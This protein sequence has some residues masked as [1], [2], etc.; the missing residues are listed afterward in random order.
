M[1]YKNIFNNPRERAAVTFPYVWW[2]DAFTDEDIN[3]IIA[4]CEKFNQSKA[5]IGSSE[6][7]QKEIDK[8]RRSDINFFTPDQENDWIFKRL[9]FIIEGLNNQFYGFDLNGYDSFQ[10]TTYH[11]E[12]EGMYDWH[13]DMFLGN[14]NLPADMSEPR[15]L[16][17]VLLL[18]EPEVDFKGGEFQIKQ[19]TDRSDETLPTRKGRI[20]AFP[21]FMLH[22]VKPVTEGIRKSL[23]VWVSGPKFK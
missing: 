9:N 8:I 20:L 11:G 18:N 5:K 21:S 4:Y 1:N 22:R 23:V 15:K 16:S 12:Q 7:D 10:Y 19:G 17:L 14:K 3:N 2:D 6:T 13:I